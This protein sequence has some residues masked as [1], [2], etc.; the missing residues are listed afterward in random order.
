MQEKL[1]TVIEFIERCNLNKVAKIF[2]RKYR[3]KGN[4]RKYSKIDI[5][6]FI[7]FLKTIPPIETNRV[8]DVL[9][10]EPDDIIIGL[11]EKND[12]SIQY[13]KSYSGSVKE[14]CSYGV[15]FVWNVR[16][17]D[18]KTA[19]HLLWITLKRITDD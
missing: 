15:D 2:Y 13:L 3:F 7:A 11:Y 10:C 19:A 17:S 4:L 9:T 16:Y 8:L 12:D 1:P 5:F 18:E 14:W 6:S